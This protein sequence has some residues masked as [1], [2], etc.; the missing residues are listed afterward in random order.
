[1]R[2]CP[3]SSNAPPPPRP[4]DLSVDSETTRSE[5]YTRVAGVVFETSEDQPG[6]PL[7]AAADARLV[8]L[9][10]FNRFFAAW[11]LPPHEA[12]GLPACRRVEMVRVQPDPAVPAGVTLYEV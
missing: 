1:M 4:L 3:Q 10:L 6:D 11:A 2:S 7:A 5:L 8:I 12:D 9:F